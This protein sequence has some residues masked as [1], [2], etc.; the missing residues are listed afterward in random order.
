MVA[1]TPS[2]V[3]GPAP[4]LQAALVARTQPDPAPAK[5]GPESQEEATLALSQ[6]G[7]A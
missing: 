2:D 4:V 1:K 3:L 6:L 7:I 5:R